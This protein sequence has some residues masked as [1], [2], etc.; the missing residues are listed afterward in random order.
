MFKIRTQKELL[1]LLPIIF[2]LI[3][4]KAPTEDPLRI[5]D[6]FKD[7]KKGYVEDRYHLSLRT[8]PLIILMPIIRALQR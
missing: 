1:Y 7:I 6:I 2:I 8:Y 3:F 5:T 4:K